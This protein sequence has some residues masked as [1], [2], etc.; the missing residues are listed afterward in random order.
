MV[1]FAPAAE[2]ASI[3]MPDYKAVTI[4]GECKK[5]DKLVLD[6]Q[7]LDKS[8]KAAKKGT[9]ENKEVRSSLVGQIQ[10]HIDSLLTA[11]DVAE[12]NN[13]TF[14]QYI[15]AGH[16]KAKNIMAGVEPSLKQL[17]AAWNHATA[18]IVI[19]S[20]GLLEAV[21]ADLV[22]DASALLAV[23]MVDYR[24]NGWRQSID[25]ALIFATG[26]KGAFEQRIA[27]RQKG[28]DQSTACAAQKARI[29]EYVVRAKAMEKTVIALDAKNGGAEKDFGKIRDE[30][31]DFANKTVAEVKEIC[32]EL[33]TLVKGLEP[34]VKAVKPGN[35]E[36]YKVLFLTES[37]MDQLQKSSKGKEKT[38]GIELK[39]IEKMATPTGMKDR[40]FQPQYSRAGVAIK[41]LTAAIVKF[42]KDIAPARKL[43]EI[44]KKLK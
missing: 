32:A 43:I 8:L 11:C 13:Q 1:A 10:V 3:T 40:Y 7:L 38:F 30:I 28:I 2:V 27:N 4:Q 19:R 22:K 41:Q 37:K 6:I 14:C 16:Q 23:G 25:S 24:G 17:E 35:K 36:S 15:T 42:E 31:I 5:L 26:L 12:K 21:D 44:G 18:L 29:K 34:R 20:V 39:E 9:I 33:E